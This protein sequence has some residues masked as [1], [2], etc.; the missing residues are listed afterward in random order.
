LN[1]LD[2]KTIVPTITSA[3]IDLILLKKQ[4]RNRST[5]K[6]CSEVIEKIS[7]HRSIQFQTSWSGRTW[8][9]HI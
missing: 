6:K 3:H 7:K 4:D 9:W 2:T 1:I 8:I 5:T